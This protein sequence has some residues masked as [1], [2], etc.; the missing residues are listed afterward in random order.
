M[1]QLSK[2]AEIRAQWVAA[3]DK[4]CDHPKT[5]R[6]YHLGAQTGDVGCL[7]CGESW[8]RGGE[9]PRREQAD[10]DG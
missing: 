4:P 10:S 8:P 2:L 1:V 6:E 3:G 7:V 9:P 5:D